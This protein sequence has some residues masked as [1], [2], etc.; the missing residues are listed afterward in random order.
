MNQ[1]GPP[2]PANSTIAR[3]VR[4]IMAPMD[5]QAQMECIAKAV[6]GDADALQRLL[7]DHHDALLARIRLHLSDTMRHQVDAEDVLQ[8]TYVRAFQAVS[9]CRFDHGA[10]FHVWLESLA[11]N[12]LRDQHR[13]LMRKKR[14]VRRNVEAAARRSLSHEQ[15]LDHLTATDSTPSRKVARSEAAATVLSSLA[16]LTEE[17]RD[18]VQLRFL[19]GWPVADVARHLGKS[20]GAVHMLCHRGLKSLRAVMSSMSRFLSTAS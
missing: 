14:D 2:N 20:E 13:Y 4:G 17:Q 10:A 11:M 19:E 16:R 6:V 9:G 3:F 1:R 7:I 12:A 15:F 8:E 5:T 18:V